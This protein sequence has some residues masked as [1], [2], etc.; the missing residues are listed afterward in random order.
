MKTMNIFRKWTVWTLLTLWTK[1]ALA[2]NSEGRPGGLSLS[3]AGPVTIGIA[4]NVG[5]EF[6]AAGTDW[7]LLCPYGTSAYWKQEP[8]P[9][10]KLVWNK[11][12]QVVERAQA[13]QM[14]AA[15]NQSASESGANW[16]GLPIFVGHPDI[17]PARWQDDRRM[18]RIVGLRAGEGGIEVQ[19]VWNDL[20]EKNREQG[21]WVYPSPVWTYDEAE[22]ARGRIVPVAMASVGMTNQPRIKNVP[23]WNAE[24]VLPPAETG[25]PTKTE[26]VMSENETKFRAAMLK[27][28]KLPDDAT[29]EQI[30]AA[31]DAH[32][33]LS[34]QT[35]ADEKAKAEN[36]KA[37]EDALTGKTTAEGA[38]TAANA[39]ATKMR[40]V[41]IN[42][43]LDLGIARG[44]ITAA[45][46][47]D[48]ETKFATNY[49][50]ASAALSTKAPVLDTKSLEMKPPG[51]DGDLSTEHGRRIAFNAA[52]DKNLEAGAKTIDEAI[53][54]M[55]GNAD[56]K[57]LLA[58]MEGG[59]K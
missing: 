21:Y 51:A 56:Q 29:D 10:G 7:A 17:D 5:A 25:T 8:D 41:A 47:P 44:V 15:F 35:E 43:H 20:G 57:A 59:A 50:D 31:Q 55:R 32:L 27:M 11:Y 12:D 53:T 13:E 40:G 18:G 38:A 58:A 33:K 2:F 19:R 24:Q 23:A 52:I 48:W 22:K 46:R 14:E 45:E 34:V 6:S 39:E 54:M 9:F 49:D 3:E 26:E 37:L 16:R 30:D 1:R 28:L 4:F 42:A 36:A